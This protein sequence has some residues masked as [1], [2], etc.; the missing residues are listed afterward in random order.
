M[1]SGPPRN[2]F[3]AA[4]NGVSAVPKWSQG[5]PEMESGPPPKGVRPAPN[6]SQGALFLLISPHPLI[7]ERGKLYHLNERKNLLHIFH[8]VELVN[9]PF[10]G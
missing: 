4:R 1:E 8:H 6:W 9:Y 3:G 7:W 2:G 10:K 5:R